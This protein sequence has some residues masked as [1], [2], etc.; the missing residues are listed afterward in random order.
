MNK[1]SKQGTNLQKPQRRAPQLSSLSRKTNTSHLTDNHSKV[2]RKQPPIQ[3]VAM[4][5]VE[6][7]NSLQYNPPKARK[8]NDAPHHKPHR[9]EAN[10]CLTS[11][12]IILRSPLPLLSS[13]GQAKAK[14]RH[15]RWRSNSDRLRPNNLLVSTRRHATVS[16]AH[17]IAVV[18]VESTSSP[19][20]ATVVVASVVLVVLLAAAAAAATA[21]LVVSIGRDALAHGL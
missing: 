20:L 18:V 7:T 14:P 13:T 12:D 6:N 8:R 15:S 5:F 1:V 19:S 9:H 10:A 2:K 21:A 4:L 3:S 16:A 17:I 11:H